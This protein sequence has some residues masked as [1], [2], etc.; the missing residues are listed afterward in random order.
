M[1]EHDR[2]VALARASLWHRFYMN[3]ILRLSAM[4][5]G[6]TAAEMKAQGKRCPCRGADDYCICQNAPDQETEAARHATHAARLAV[7]EEAMSSLADEIVAR[8]VQGAAMGMDTAALRK[9][10]R[11]PPGPTR[12]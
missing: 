11:T 8:A 9:Y 1:L 4:A 2:Q 5:P 12:A 3:E 10:V 6:L 7:T